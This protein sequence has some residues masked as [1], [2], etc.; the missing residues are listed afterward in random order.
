MAMQACRVF[1][2]EE[3]VADARLGAVLAGCRG[4][5]YGD[6][7]FETMR[8]DRGAI[9]WWPAHWA[10]LE[11]GAHRLGIPLPSR[12]IVESQRD[13][14][15]AEAPDAAIK[16]M[17]IRGSGGR[18][19]APAPDAP[20]LWLLSAHPLPPAAPADGLRLRWC[21]TGLAS[22]PRLAGLKHC[23]RL[24]QVLARAEWDALN[25]DE[26]GCDDGLMCDQDG[27]VIAA[28]SANVFVY[29]ET[30]GGGMPAGWA[31]P[32]LDRCGIAGVCRGWAIQALDAREAALTPEDVAAADAV[33]LCNALRGIL[34][35]AQL[36]ARRWARHPAL[37]DAQARLA[38]AHPGFA[39]HPPPAHAPH[40]S[41]AEASSVSFSVPPAADA[42]AEEG[43]A[44]DRSEVRP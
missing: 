10:R 31:T 11:E 27:R 15:L 39:A 24:E 19:Y 14:L 29:R 9:A 8:A 5:A 16:L 17:L 6:G 2:G 42:S 35:V 38:V 43:V 7:L 4:L 1:V 30:P 23:N 33:F 12:A 13:A 18:G 26:A 36:G 34:P 41:G 22:Q 21:A 32:R 40:G 37:A 25:A 28:T 20:P 44:A 3:R